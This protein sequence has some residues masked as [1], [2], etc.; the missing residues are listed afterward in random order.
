[1]KRTYNAGLDS[2]KIAFGATVG[3]VGVAYTSVYCKRTGGQQ[4]KLA[5]S[6]KNSGDIKETG[7]GEAISLKGSYLIITT[8]IDFSAFDKKQWEQLKD[9][10]SVRYKLDGGFSGT[11]LY[12]HDLDDVQPIMDGKIV[13]VT[14]PIEIL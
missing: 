10:I 7:I 9:T 1:M 14:K 8:Y 2:N 13:I 6:N 11:Q 3:T 12:N 4:T 5:E